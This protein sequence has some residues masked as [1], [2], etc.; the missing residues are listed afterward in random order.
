[1]RKVYDDL[2]KL[3]VEFNLGKLIATVVAVNLFLILPISLVENSR[4]NSS[5]TIAVSDSGRVLGLDSSAETITTTQYQVLGVAFDP[6]TENGL[7]VTIGLVLLGISFL[8][9]VFLIVDNQRSKRLKK[10]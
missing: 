5:N 6:Q 9:L 10:F 8:I 3:K 7:L 2:P 4:N 1:M